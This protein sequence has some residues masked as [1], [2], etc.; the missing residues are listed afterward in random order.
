MKIPRDSQPVDWSQ[1]DP[2]RGSER[3]F[4]G[5][6]MIFRDHRGIVDVL[7]REELDFGQQQTL[8]SLDGCFK[9]SSW[10]CKF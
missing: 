7:R 2:D 6:L 9:G 4:D 8:T 5:N 10:M 3:Y 1:Q